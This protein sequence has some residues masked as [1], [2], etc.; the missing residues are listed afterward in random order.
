MSDGGS[1]PESAGPV[2]VP[3]IQDSGLAPDL[4]GPSLNAKAPGIA[5]REKTQIYALSAQREALRQGEI[6]TEVCQY[7]RSLSSLKDQTHELEEIRHP[8][9]VVVSQDCDLEQDFLARNATLTTG[10]SDDKLLPSVLL[11]QAVTIE[12][13]RATTPKGG[14]RWKQ[15]RQNKNERYHVLEAVQTKHDLAG[16]GLPPLGLDFKR[17]FTVPADELYQQLEVSAHRRCRME[18]PYLEQLTRRFAD[19]QSRIA[20]PREHQVD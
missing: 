14:E 3:A 15:I 13:L 16:S 2:G 1:P 7:R 5:P 6:L 9:A 18:S 11:L 12:E 20:L 19:Y 4:K 8:F 10:S 17:Y